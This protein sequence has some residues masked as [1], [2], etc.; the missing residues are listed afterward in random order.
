MAV[1]R[2]TVVLKDEGGVYHCVTRCVRRAFLCGEDYATG[3]SYDHR[4]EW[5]RS[6]LDK[7][8]RAFGVD[9]LAYSVMSNHLH[10]V[11]RTRPEVSAGWTDEQ[12]ARRWLSVYTPKHGD[13]VHTDIEYKVTEADVSAIMEEPAR[14]EEL[15]GRLWNLSWFMKALNEHIA[16]RANKEDGCT[17]HFWESRF[18]CQRLLDDGAVLACMCY[19][20]LNPVRAQV[21][22]S[23]EDS[24]FT[25]AYDRIMARKAASRKQLLELE[26]QQMD[27]NILKQE[28]TAIAYRL[29]RVSMLV[30]L[31][32]TE[33]PS[34]YWGTTQYLQILDW[35]GRH[36]QKDK[37]GVISDEIRPVL[38]SLELDADEW[39]ESVRKYRKRFR[40]MAGTSAHI[41]AAAAHAGRAWFKG[42]RSCEAVFRKRDLP[43]P[44]P[45]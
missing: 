22:E 4:K 2:K 35:T 42:C 36:L 8:S 25:S 17:G 1:A 11:L 40:L 26:A 34:P 43:G 41:R 32:G 21:A 9:V 29:E 13:G 16:R 27:Q 15:R 45:A 14:V 24:D 19:V 37:P 12:V 38:E 20:D 44:A 28:Q 39:V 10:A 30:D 3:K 5:I 31:D 18:K 7:L 23:L 6:R 33:A